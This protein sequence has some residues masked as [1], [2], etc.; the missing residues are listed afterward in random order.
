[1]KRLPLLLL[2]LLM[3]LGMPLGGYAQS[4]IPFIRNITP[5][6]Y[7]AHNRNFD[8]VCDNDGHVFVANFE[9][10][11][12]SDHAEWHI[13]HTPGISRI[14][15]LYRDS[16]GQIWAGG[17]N[18]IGKVTPDSHGRM[19]LHTVGK[20]TPIQGEVS[21]IWE[22]Y[23]KHFFVVGDSMV[24]AIEG[25]RI[26]LQ[27][28]KRAAAQSQPVYDNSARVT[29]TQQLGGGLQAVATG[30]S[31][32]IVTDVRGNTL[33]TVSE[34][35][36][37]CSNN[38]SSI[39]YDGR[40]TLWGATDNGL[41]AIAAPSA[42]SH[43]TVNEGLRGEVLSMEKHQGHLYVG[44]VSGLY[45]R[46]GM[47]FSPVADIHYACWM[48]QS[49]G[50]R[51]L[52]ATSAGVFSIGA[53]GQ[54]SL[55]TGAATT[56]IM[57]RGNDFFSGELD[58]VY[59][60]HS[61]GRRERIGGQQNVTHFFEDDND[62]L[63]MQNLYGQVWRKTKGDDDFV[64]Y[65]RQGQADT[66]AAVAALVEVNHAA[67]V[68]TVTDTIPFS[69]P[70]FSYADDSG[71]TWLTDNEGRRLYAWKDG[72]PI[73]AYD[74][75]LFPIGDVGV[76]A[77]LA[78]DK[79][80][81]IGGDNG[82]T[83]IDRQMKD[84]MVNQNPTLSI[85]SVMVTGDSVLWGGF[86]E[87]P[88]SLPRLTRDRRNLRFTFALNSIPPIGQ[89]LYRYR[90]SG[91][92]WSAWSTDVVANFFNHPAGAYTL[93]VQAR[94]AFGRLTDTV[95]MDFTI[96]YPFYIRWYMI[97]AYLLLFTAAVFAVIRW[98]LQR[99]EK[100]KNRLEH[101]VEERTREVVQQKNEI[102]EK[103]NSL[104]R[105]LHDLNEAQHELI[106]Q[107]KMATVGKLTQGLIDRILNPLNY[108]NNFAKLSEGLVGD[109]EAN[110]EDDKETMNQENYEDT[111]DVL[112]MLR[113]NLK[114]VGEHGQSTTRTL[115][116]MEEMLKDRSGGIVPMDLVP[117]LQQDY[118]M[119][120]KYYEADIANYHISTVLDMPQEHL[121]VNGNADQLS[122]TFM[123][124]LGNAVYAIVKK[125][126]RQQ[127]QP[128]LKIAV[129]QSDKKLTIT[130]SDNG[131]GIEDTIVNKV[132]DPF[133]TTKPT[134]E[135]SGVGLY[136][137]REIIQNH[138]GDISVESQKDTFTTFTITLPA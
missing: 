122:K 95:G 134:G 48:L 133:F 129:V 127:F 7:G 54:V 86:G 84:P 49:Q 28:G 5:R 87:C 36:G 89:V 72:H 32:L 45:R 12:Y 59:M 109:L 51:L 24:Y 18:Y 68:V 125:A 113:G 132:F 35:N 106:R 50:D 79:F 52:V 99:L 55:L 41:F 30:G 42:Y 8:I 77:M 115:K 47:T 63:W 44:T 61:D 131:I 43:F 80:L 57:V 22:E 88:K 26:V 137:S 4:G 13:L 119:L 101:I 110:I 136:L 93:E 114:K 58:G 124:L 107:E 17:Y 69:Y 3:M 116:A 16:N 82:L 97:V 91:G 29:K 9:G 39:D 27:S 64:P 98:R 105:A 85:R 108:I 23:D 62:C 33:Y 56:A 100:E 112:D 71:C 25:D 102:E 37:L 73:H 78:D 15:D 104:E 76:R 1:M 138:G 130:V 135:A 75:L 74:Q 34:V 53:N 121:A 96:D 118:A 19:Q 60:N 90:V 70:L 46:D 65:V 40:G 126:Q 120:Q 2:L 31:G 83:V 103:S 11:L 21:H 117:V 94:D 123:S 67:Q 10:L 14:T 66:I 111:C 6:E 128:E 92:E 38:I 81:W 20:D